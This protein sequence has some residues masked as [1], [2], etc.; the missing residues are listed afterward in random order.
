MPD[1]E[2]DPERLRREL[3]EIRERLQ[4]LGGEGDAALKQLDEAITEVERRLATRGGE[5]E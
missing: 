3:Q 1:E 4:R 2:F 5:P